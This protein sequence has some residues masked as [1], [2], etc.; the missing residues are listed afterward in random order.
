MSSNFHHWNPGVHNDCFPRK[1]RMWISHQKDILSLYIKWDFILLPT[2]VCRTPPH[3]YHRGLHR[4]AAGSPANTLYNNTSQNSLL[5]CQRLFSSEKSW[6]TTLCAHTSTP[7]EQILKP[8]TKMGLSHS[9]RLRGDGAKELSHLPAVQQEGNPGRLREPMSGVSNTCPSQTLPTSLPRLCITSLSHGRAAWRTTQVPEVHRKAPGTTGPKAICLWLEERERSCWSWQREL[10][11]PEQCWLRLLCFHCWC[12]C[13]AVVSLSQCRLLGTPLQS[14]CRESVQQ[15]RSCISLQGWQ[16]SGKE[17]D[18][19]MKEK[20]L[21]G[22]WRKSH[23]LST[24]RWQSPEGFPR[25]LRDFEHN[26]AAETAE[27]EILPSCTPRVK[28]SLL[29]SPCRISSDGIEKM[30]R[31]VLWWSSCYQYTADAASHPEIW[32]Q[33]RKCGEGRN[34]VCVCPLGGTTAASCFMSWGCEKQT[35]AWTAMSVP[36]TS[37]GW[38]LL[39]NHTWNTHASGLPRNKPGLLWSHII[40]KMHIQNHLLEPVCV[41]FNTEEPTKH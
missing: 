11:G 23:L 13:A 3:Q 5:F 40:A 41:L 7:P 17:T 29:W 1:P 16:T 15:L 27:T 26:K 25:P 33:L 9:T 35:S 20:Q 28:R 30:Q 4:R 8:S 22:K 12:V 34:C 6:H 19:N 36:L 39:H 32:R 2:K 14:S 18:R 38:H 10:W 21:T 31:S 24:L 37:M